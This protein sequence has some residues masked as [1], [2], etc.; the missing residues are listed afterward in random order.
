MAR[1]CNHSPRPFLPRHPSVPIISALFTETNSTTRVG[2]YNDRVPTLPP[3][4]TAG[5]GYDSSPTNQYPF[6]S[7]PPFRLSAEART[8]KV[9]AFCDFRG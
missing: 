8:A 5:A 1:V 9:D 3:R 2:E 6:V 4:A 7:N